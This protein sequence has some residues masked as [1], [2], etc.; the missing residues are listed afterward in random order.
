MACFVWVESFRQQISA[1]SIRVFSSDP[2]QQAKTLRMVT[3]QQYVKEVTDFSSQYGS[4]SSLSYTVANVAGSPRI[5][6]AYGDFTQA[7]VFRSYGP[8]W[9]QCPSAPQPFSRTSETFISQDFVELLYEEKVYPKEIKIMETFNPGAVVRI[10]ALKNAS[11]EPE[12]LEDSPRWY[13]LWCGEPEQALQQSRIFSPTINNVDFPTNVIRLEF[14]H[15]CL[16]YYTELDAVEL[17]GTKAKDDEG[18]DLDAAYAAH[19]MKQLQISEKEGSRSRGVI[20]ISSGGHPVVTENGCFDMLPTELIQYIFS[21]LDVPSLCNAALTC[22]LF[23][24][25]CYDPL[26]YVELDL[27]P[28]WT[29]I[30]DSALDGL[31]SRCRH[32]QRLNLSWTGSWGML[33]PECF[34][35]FIEYCG[36]ELTTLRLSCCYFLNAACLQVISETCT[37]LQELDLQSCTQLDNSAFQHI[38]KL[39]NLQTL[40][41]Y[42]CSIGD[43][44]L[45]QIIKSLPKLEHLN[46]GSCV[47]IANCDNIL[48]KLSTYC[49]NLKS[50]DLWRSRSLTHIG[51]RALAN[52]CHELL[53]L[54][55]GW[56]N[57]LNSN[58]QCF[59]SLVQNCPKLRKLF[60]TANRSVCDADMN[61]ISLHALQLEQLDILGTRMVSPTSVGCV[62]ENCQS[63]ALCDLSFCLM[64]DAVT[65]LLWKETFPHVSIKKSFTH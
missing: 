30:D 2:K 59:V 35:R 24:K 58:T 23:Y 1:K 63:L 42:R 29:Q 11:L 32:L 3:L 16:D 49:K 6:P 39:T 14:N 5:Y 26:Q 37:S 41:L 12:S 25:H 22:T 52:N 31:Q 19:M 45:I 43:P 64:L 40:N 65:V 55:L 46:L 4:E 44:T 13:E 56:C 21:Y 57:E 62:L 10:L 8:W 7:L 36:S 27:Q 20:P 28:Y 53:E 60:L 38:N 54:D 48:V 9:Q 15:S 33:S 61:A 17:V 18:T 51:L 50:L 47:S 34:S